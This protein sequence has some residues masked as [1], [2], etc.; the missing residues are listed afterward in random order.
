[1]T[2]KD[3][4]ITR[5]GEIKEQIIR[6]L[7]NHSNGELSKYRI[8]KLSEGSQTWVYDYINQLE[9]EGYIENT[10]VTNIRALF[11]IWKKNRSKPI[12]KQYL[13]KKP[14]QI[15]ESVKK[16]YALTTYRA[17]NLIQN[18]LFPTRTDIYCKIEDQ[19]YWHSLLSK[20][21]IVGGGNFRTLYAPKH[22]FFNSYIINNYTTVSTP[23]L[24]VDLLVEGG[25]SAE[26][27][28]M[29]IN[30]LVSKNV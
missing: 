4:P 19:N 12:E 24:I 1:M 3:Q 9:K 16:D 8:W 26:A 27:A 20:K 22:V 28:D 5:R 2:S 10:K 23:Q 11:E 30:K 13:I 7:L 18:H 6:V 25:P 29:L 21:G 17:E 14:M 15:L